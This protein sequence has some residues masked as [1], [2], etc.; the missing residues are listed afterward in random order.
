MNT[1]DIDNI[2]VWLVTVNY[3]ANC[4]DS[5]VKKVYFELLNHV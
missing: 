4:I 1:L 2:D 3:H 5:L